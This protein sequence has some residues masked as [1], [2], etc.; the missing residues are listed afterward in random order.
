[1][2]WIEHALENNRQL[3]KL[4]S[5][6]NKTESD[7]LERDLVDMSLQLNVCFLLQSKDMP[8]HVN[9]KHNPQFVKQRMDEWFRMRQKSVVTA[10]SA[11][12]AIGMRTL[13]EQKI[14]H[15][16][17]IMKND[18]PI[19]DELTQKKMTHGLEN[20]VSCNLHRFLTHYY[21]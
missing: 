1:M 2:E 18:P 3:C 16:T 15:S 20:E 17:Y 7:F 19:T 9:L 6:I 5:D 11:Y 13:K 4:M 14:H 10:S 8:P 21:D 12:T